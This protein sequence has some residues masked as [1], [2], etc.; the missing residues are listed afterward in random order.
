MINGHREAYVRA[1]INGEVARLASASVGERNKTLFKATAALASIGVREG[2]IIHHLRPAAEAIGLHGKE[3]YSTIK[4]G[5]KAGNCKP[6]S[7]PETAAASGMQP[8]LPSATSPRADLPARSAP[9]SEGRPTFFQG[10]DEGPR[11]SSDEMRRHIYRRAG[12]PVRVKIKFKSGGFANW[13]RVHDQ[14]REG[15]Q[16][17]KPDGFCHARTSAP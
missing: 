12:K 17:G 4:S 9:D 13:Y 8:W 3:F 15:W 10:C 6:R 7:M 2:Q 16:A 5:V 14:G 1:A 11:E